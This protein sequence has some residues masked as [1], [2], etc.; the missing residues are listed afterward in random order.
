MEISLKKNRPW[1]YLWMT[2][3]AGDATD[4]H[5]RFHIKTSAWIY[6]RIQ[7]VCTRPK[8]T[9]PQNLARIPYD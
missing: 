7:P 6:K 8:L 5:T 9:W 4:V 2:A 3:L 1:K